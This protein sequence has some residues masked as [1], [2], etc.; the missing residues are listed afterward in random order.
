MRKG[1][2][3]KNDSAE[4][5]NKQGK[6]NSSI[7]GLNETGSDGAVIYFQLQNSRGL[8]KKDLRT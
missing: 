3:N 2:G 5:V 7:L 6:L 4:S 8:E 1:R